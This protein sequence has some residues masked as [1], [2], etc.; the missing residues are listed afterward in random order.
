MKYLLAILREVDE[1]YDAFMDDIAKGYLFKK[2]LARRIYSLDE[3]NSRGCKISVGE[4]PTIIEQGRMRRYNANHKDDGQY[5]VLSDP[6]T[7]WFRD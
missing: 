2:S 7:P 5:E 1:I 6:F 3:L 4:G